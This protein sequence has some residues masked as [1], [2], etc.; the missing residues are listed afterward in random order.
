VGEAFGEASDCGGTAL[1]KSLTNLWGKGIKPQ[2]TLVG[3]SAGSIYIS[4]LLKELDTAMPPDFE[5]N[6]VFIA[7]A[8]TFAVFADAL[9]V[10]GKRISGLR[11]FG[12]GNE[13]EMKDAIAGPL[14]PA[15]LLYFVSGIV[16]DERDMPLLGMERYYGPPYEGAGFE[17]LAVDGWKYS[18]A[19]SMIIG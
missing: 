15:S 17:T 9:K 14:Y 18:T 12:M 10:G 6:I 5:F 8:C 1:V 11:I 16:E 2:V 19:M 7:P 13:R 3:H 4:R